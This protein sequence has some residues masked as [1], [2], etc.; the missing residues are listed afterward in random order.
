MSLA[1]AHKADISRSSSNVRFWGVKRTSIGRR[2]KATAVNRGKS[3]PLHRDEREAGYNGAVD[4]CSCIAALR[5]DYRHSGKQCGDDTEHQ[6]KWDHKHTHA[7]LS[8]RNK[9]AQGGLSF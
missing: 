9:A 2:R 7:G 8:A 4:C 1:R 6:F 5:T 3:C